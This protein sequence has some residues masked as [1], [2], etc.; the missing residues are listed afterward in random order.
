VFAGPNGSG[1][2]TI[3]NAVKAYRVSNIPVD[4]GIYVNADDIAEA[5]LHDTFAFAA[6][7]VQVLNEEFI[8]TAKASGLINV[9]FP[10]AVFIRSFELSQN[11]ITFLPKQ[12]KN[13]RERLAQVLADFLR[14]KL[15][16]EKKKFSFET[17]F[18]HP[19]KLDIMR[20]AAA[21]GYKVY[22]YFVSTESPEINIY[23][24]EVRKAKGGH[25]VNPEKIRSRYKRS[26]DLL[27][28]AA[29]IA[30]QTFFF[31][32]STDAAQR[33]TF[34]PF[35]HFKVVKGK[36]EWDALDESKVPDWFIKYYYNKVNQNLK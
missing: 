6:Y 26:L 9:D 8:Q 21:A 34:E 24:V 29:Q 2:T 35:A 33:D 25:D 15:L 22:L 14:K 32:N 19:S 18:S 12:D 3:I 13:T 20:Q 31:D 36:K 5:L 4:F 11:K 23:R 27:Y 1:K 16:K 28:E 17:V 7:E 30:Y 10:E